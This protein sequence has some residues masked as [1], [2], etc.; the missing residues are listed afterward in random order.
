[1]K[2]KEEQLCGEYPMGRLMLEAW[3]AMQR[4]ASRGRRVGHALGHARVEG[5]RFAEWRCG[6]LAAVVGRRSTWRT[7]C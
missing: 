6:E 5:L 2:E 1:M 3:N 7:V 4:L